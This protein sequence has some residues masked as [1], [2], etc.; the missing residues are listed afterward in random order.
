MAALSEQAN[1]FLSKYNNK[2]SIQGDRALVDIY[3]HYFCVQTVFEKKGFRV[4]KNP[5]TNLPERLE[6]DLNKCPD[7]AQTLAITCTGLKIRCL[8]IGLET[9]KIK[10][11]DR[12]KS[13]LIELEKVGA[14]V[15]HS[16]NSLEILNFKECYPK[17]ICLDTYQDHR[18]AMAVVPLALHTKIIIHNPM[19]VKKSYPAFWK[20]LKRLDFSIIVL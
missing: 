11:T 14:C 10:E 7:I 8:L 17:T 20:D 4:K 15:K 1:I 5:F 13:M 18:M 2:K 19:V 6:F 16:E 12:I 9:L 3:S